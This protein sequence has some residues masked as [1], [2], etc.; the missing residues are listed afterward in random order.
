[1]KI[2]FIGHSDFVPTEKIE[3][4]L[5]NI[6]EN[7]PRDEKIEFYLGGYGNFDIFAKKCCKKYQVLNKS[8]KLY[9]VSPYLTPSFLNSIKNQSKD[10]DQIIT[11]KSAEKPRKYTIIKRNYE[12]ISLADLIISYVDF[13]FGGAYKSFIYAIKQKKH[14]VN[15]GSL[16]VEKG[17]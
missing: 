10:Y 6:L 13:S 4:Q 8:A 1:M 3:E 2:T 5:Q 16:E 9:L 17:D 15:L 7:L 14:I 12:M 11:F